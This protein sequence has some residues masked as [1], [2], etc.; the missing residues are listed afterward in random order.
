VMH[1]HFIYNNK[2]TRRYWQFETI[3]SPQLMSS[4]REKTRGACFT[5]PFFARCL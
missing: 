5:N 1:F 2:W 4:E 3:P